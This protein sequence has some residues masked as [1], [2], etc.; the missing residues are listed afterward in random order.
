MFGKMPNM[1]QQNSLAVLH[2]PQPANANIVSPEK[3]I[4]EFT[5]SE[6]YNLHRLPKEEAA[7][8]RKK[9][10]AEGH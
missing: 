10:E 5:Y 1:V 9:L 4:F 7:A 3:P 2:K 8:I 6:R